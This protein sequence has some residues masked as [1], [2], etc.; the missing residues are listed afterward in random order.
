MVIKEITGRRSIRAYLDN[1]VEPEKLER[2]L[3]AARLAPSAKN[4][5]D[6]R[7]V[8][9]A[10]H[11]LKK[12]LINAATPHQGF[13]HEAPIIIAAC[14]TNPDYIMRCGQAAY[15]IDLAI[16]LDHLSLQA[17]AEGLGT[18][19]IGSFD[20][21]PVKMILGIPQAVKVVELMTLGYPAFNHEPA[22][23]KKLSDL[24]MTNRWQEK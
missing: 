21:E 19:W 15:P 14:A 17:V 20:E 2:V 10:D 3:E 22:A 4:R 16:V 18:C 7:L 5:Q 11:D 12:D 13:M 1:P 23:R 9:V 6:W 24:T 8:I